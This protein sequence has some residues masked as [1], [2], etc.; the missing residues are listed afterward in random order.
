[1]A[2]VLTEGSRFSEF[3]M[4]TEIA[5]FLIVTIWN[6][7]AMDVMNHILFDLAQF[8]KLLQ[9]NDVT[10]RQTNKPQTTGDQ[11]STFEPSVQVD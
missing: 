7:V 11:E 8:V 10:D 6:F 2:P 5:L 3:K 4:Y 9:I 1:M